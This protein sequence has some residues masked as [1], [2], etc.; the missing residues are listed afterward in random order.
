M[1]AASRLVGANP[2][3]WFFF[4]AVCRVPCK[5]I[6]SS[7]KAEREVSPVPCLCPRGARLCAHVEPGFVPTWSQAV[8]WQPRQ[9]ADRS[10]KR[11]LRPGQREAT[12]REGLPG[13]RETPRECQPSSAAG[14]GAPQGHETVLRIQGSVHGVLPSGATPGGGRGEDRLQGC[15]PPA[16]SGWPFQ[17]GSRSKFSMYV[18][19]CV[20]VYTYSFP[21]CFIT[22][23]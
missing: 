7:R 22:Q 1:W 12:L 10:A 4:V 18:C 15:R 23:Y 20:C 8:K 6:T 19:V 9:R 2:G 16:E 21:L 3:T 14:A 5:F 11:S 17:G 13:Q